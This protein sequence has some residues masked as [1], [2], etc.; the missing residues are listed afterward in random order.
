METKKDILEYLGMDPTK[1]KFIEGQLME[2]Y[3]SKI[4]ENIIKRK[5]PL[6]YEKR[7]GN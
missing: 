4:V 3:I 1:N 6:L 2:K 5:F 7:Y